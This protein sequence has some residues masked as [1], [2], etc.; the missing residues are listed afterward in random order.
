VALGETE[1]SCPTLRV[2]CT[3]AML[4]RIIRRICREFLQPLLHF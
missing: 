2:H 4:H 1:E 3:I